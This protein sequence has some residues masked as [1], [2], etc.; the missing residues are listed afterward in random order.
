LTKDAHDSNGAASVFAPRR[1]RLAPPILKLL[2]H[3]RRI[4]SRNFKQKS[5]TRINIFA[6]AHD[7]P[8]FVKGGAAM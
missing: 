5:G 7:F 4:R 6:S 2:H 1:P 3:K 8:K